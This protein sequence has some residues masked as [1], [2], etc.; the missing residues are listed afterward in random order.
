MDALLRDVE[1]RARAVRA[2]IRVTVQHALLWN[3]G[4]EMVQLWDAERAS[5]VNPLDEWIAA[6][7]DLAAGTDIVRPFNHMTNV[8]GMATRGTKAAGVQSAAH[9]MR[10]SRAIELHTMGT[11]RLDGEAGRRGSEAPGNLADLFACRVDPLSAD[12]DSLVDLTPAF[13]IAGGWAGHDPGG[14]L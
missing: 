8:W 1:Q 11:A 5:R 2:S 12:P 4:S 6:G 14:R 9:V 10:V 13:T 3:M 7:A